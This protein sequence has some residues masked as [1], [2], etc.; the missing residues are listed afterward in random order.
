VR[1]QTH[2]W[3]QEYDRELTNLLAVQAEIAY[4][5][6]DAIQLTLG[7]PKAN[8]VMQ[9]STLTPQAYQAYDLYLKGLFFW[10]KRTLP[11][12]QQAIEYFRQAI[13]KDPSYAP[14][15]AGLANSYTLLT[16][17]SVSPASK[18]M[19][20]AR[21]A[22][23]RALELDDSLPEAHTALA[24]VVENYDWDWST[25]EKEFR[26]AIE[27]NPNYATA[28]HWYAEH[29]TWQG[30]FAEAF[31]ESEI[32]RSLDPLS[33]IINTDYGAIFYYSRQYDRAIEQFSAVLDMDPKFP[34]ALMVIDA[35]IEKGMYAEALARLEA[36][37]RESGDV[38]WIHAK[39]AHVYGRSGQKE[40]AREELEKLEKSNRD[41]PMDPAI[42][43]VANLDAGDK[44]GAL[45]LLEKAYSQ[46]SNILT[47]IKVDPAYDALRSDPRFE[48]L[49]RRV[50]LAK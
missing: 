28:H 8:V 11:G 29:L 43:V 15:Y 4:E 49:L 19:P 27:L 18:Y 25:S 5:I 50:G 10:N 13:G 38:P 48:E 35:Y 42:F 22:A 14:A 31:K 2:L 9:K 41:G 1:G 45:T 37:R 23:L 44:K 33:L 32:A 30:R 16:S 6:A 3:A 36:N 12:F 34:H 7:D 40:K 47:T 24:L 21:E 17:Y 39:L 20:Q 46:H 26:R